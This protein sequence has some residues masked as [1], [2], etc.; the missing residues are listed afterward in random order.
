[1][2]AWL[3]PFATL[4]GAACS[5]APTAQ[6]SATTL[7]EARWHDAA[8]DRDVPVRI[9]MP[10]GKGRVPLILF[11]HGL[12]GSLDAGTRWAEAWAA[13][14]FAV[15]HLQHPGSDG[16]AILGGGLMRAMSS[17]QLR[18]RAGDVHFVLDAVKKRPREGECDLSR[19]DLGRIGMSGHSFGAQTTLAIAGTHYPFGS[20]ADPRVRAAVALSPQPAVLADSIAFGPIRMPFL[21]ITGSEDALPRLNQVTPKDRERPF[22]A[23]APGDKYLLVMEGGTHAMFGG[24]DPA[25]AHIQDAVTR[26][27][28]LFWRATLRDDKAAKAELQRF[29]TALGPGD[30]F[31]VR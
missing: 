11:S 7:C 31:E 4:A 9:R 19:L 23:M 13:D 21:S 3:I 14:G 30:R 24:R 22:R 25:P 16:P 29:A 12:G 28:L 6:A 27:T 2:K 8:R 5:V 26:A 20:L 17:D 18:N 1:M 15:I 10:E